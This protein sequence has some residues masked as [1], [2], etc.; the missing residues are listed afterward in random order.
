MTRRELIE[1]LIYELRRDQKS[2]LHHYRKVVQKD[3]A[4][5]A[6][7]G[8]AL[9]RQQV[10]LGRLARMKGPGAKKRQRFVDSVMKRSVVPTKLEK[11]V[12]DRA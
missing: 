9:A 12:R 2:F 6:G 5:G 4:A 10:A 7:V 3:G 1:A 8:K 11:L